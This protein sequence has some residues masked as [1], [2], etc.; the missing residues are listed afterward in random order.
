MNVPTSGI[1][2]PGS[3]SVGQLAVQAL[4]AN[5]VEV[6]FGIPGTHNLE[7]YRGLATS[8]I[9][10]I[11]PRHEQ[12]AGYA[13]DGYARSSGKPGVVI[14]TSGPGILNAATALATSYA[15][16]V[17]VLAISPGPPTGT[18]NK[19]VGWLH[20]VKDQRAALDAIVE[21]SVRAYTA[22]DVV[23]VI[24]EVFFQW[25]SGRTHPVHLEIPVDVLELVSPQVAV[26]AY[27]APHPQVPDSRHID[28]ALRL[29]ASASTPL[30]VAGGGSLAAGEELLKLAEAISAPIVT[31]VAGK[32]VVS[33]LHPLAAGV[34]LPYAVD[35]LDHADLLVIVGSEL[36]QVD[37]EGRSLP[38]RA[39]VI[40]VDVSPQ[41]VHATRAA[42]VA[43]VGQA[44]VTLKAVNSRGPLS[45]ATATSA[46][47]E[48]SR[49][50]ERIAAAH[51]QWASLH[52]ML[53]QVL[54]PDAVICGDSSQVSY[55][56]TAPCF[57]ATQPRQFL[58]PNGFATLGY[59]I[60]AAIGAQVAVPDRTVL[61]LLG[62]GALTFSVQ[63]LLTAAQEQLPICAIVID[64]GGYG[65]IRQQQKDRDIQ[66][67]G[68]D[69]A[70]AD[71]VGLARACG[72]S[73]AKVATLEQLSEVL[74]GA[75]AA[76]RGPSLYLIDASAAQNT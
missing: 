41:Q 47:G 10:H 24:N 18:E 5:D 33:E 48:A 4:R 8:G 44:Q 55:L 64:N 42:N 28:E 53:A 58:Y 1:C 49:I 30:I 40:R 57:P 71:L 6:V 75:I 35:A 70:D 51:P 38:L 2:T 7:L 29:L 13:A 16:S 67:L 26:Q 12:G 60:P 21:R 17:P 66:P 34:A 61:A 37:L 59:A 39:K 3:P 36:A 46:A 76:R 65:E 56:G 73:A 45:L 72:W 20:E 31:T 74:T 63:E 14:A 9:R 19:R 15:D 43:L 25:Q 50:R 11:A 23:S 22:A 62:D 68:V 54:P 27:P 52:A 32:G 69:F